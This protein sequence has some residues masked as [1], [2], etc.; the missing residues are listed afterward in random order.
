LKRRSAIRQAQGEWPDTCAIIT[1]ATPGGAPRRDEPGSDPDARLTSPRWSAGIE[2]WLQCHVGID[3][4]A[5]IIRAVVITP[6][7]GNDTV[8]ADVLIRGDERAVLADAAYHS[9]VIRY[10]VSQRLRAR[11]LSPPWPSPCAAG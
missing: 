1:I 2:L 9:R 5:G 7:N 3:E 11:C 6:A 8:P 10:V 4:G